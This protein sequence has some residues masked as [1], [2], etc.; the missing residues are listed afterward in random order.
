M[1]NIYRFETWIDFISWFAMEKTYLCRFLIFLGFRI[2]HSKFPAWIELD[3]HLETVSG[4]QLI[5]LWKT[6]F[7]GNVFFLLSCMSLLVFS[8]W[9]FSF[10]GFHL[11]VTS[12]CTSAQLS[13][14]VTFLFIKCF[15]HW[16]AFHCS[17]ADV[18]LKPMEFV[19]LT[20]CRNNN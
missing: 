17:I 18:H 1:R 7:L 12:F 4:L 3:S 15:I 8:S 6:N 5:G 16:C 20:V 2:R 14:V 13:R 19:I 9:R 11:N 10:R